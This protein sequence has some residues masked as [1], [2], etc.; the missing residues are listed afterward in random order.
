[1]AKN[2]KKGEP[3]TSPVTQ[4]INGIVEKAGDI[5]LAIA[6]EAEAKQ[7]N[8]NPEIAWRI[9]QA[10]SELLAR[11][12]NNRIDTS[13]GIIEKEPRPP[14]TLPVPVTQMPV[15]PD[16][17]PVRWRQIN[18]LPGYRVQ[19][20]RD[21]GNDVF[22]GFPCF[23]AFQKQT[24]AKNGD[25]HG[26]VLTVSDFTHDKSTISQM[27]KLIAEKGTF[28]DTKEIDYGPRAPNYRP[29]V[30][31]FMTDNWT[32]KLVQDKIENGAPINLN[33]IY[34]WPGGA[35]FYTPKLGQAEQPKLPT[36]SSNN[37]RSLKHLG[38]GDT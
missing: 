36:G 20:I 27:A 9:G 37:A 30:I 22:M 19:P 24:L 38:H 16:S 35:N 1:M 18:Q 14:Q 3:V 5:P 6:N 4:S 7:L 2:L 8:L 32:F 33:A 23:R 17:A 15:L 10:V 25:A 31:L 13:R 28:L 29:R 34:A 21:L 26:E 12:S 11:L